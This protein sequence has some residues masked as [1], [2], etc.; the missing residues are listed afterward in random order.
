MCLK[1]VFLNLN[2]KCKEVSIATQKQPNQLATTPKHD[3]MSWSR[4]RDDV[5]PNRPTNASRHLR[6][7]VFTY[8]LALKCGASMC[9]WGRACKGTSDDDDD[10]MPCHG[11][12][13]QS[14]ET[15]LGNKTIYDCAL[16]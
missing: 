16:C 9:R 10:A 3:K 12:P 7:N 8:N 13:F 14:P 5:I 1:G 2:Y 4:F 11:F 15:V 6:Y